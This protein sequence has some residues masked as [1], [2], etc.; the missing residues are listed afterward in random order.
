L[1]TMWAVSALQRGCRCGWATGS[2]FSSLGIRSLTSYVS[3]AEAR[4]KIFGWA[5]LDGDRQRFKSLQRLKTKGFVGH[6]HAQYYPEPSFESKHPVIRRAANAAR[7]AKLKLR[8]QLGQAPPK[9]GEGKR[10]GR[11]K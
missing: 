8:Q 4:Q 2:N 9:K 7:L 11:K 3:V 10:A 6:R 1:S 5:K